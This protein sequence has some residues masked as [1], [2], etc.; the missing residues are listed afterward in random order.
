MTVMGQASREWWSIKEGKRLLIGVE[1][2]RSLEGVDFPP[3]L[4]NFLLLF[5]KA[6]VEISA[7]FVHND[8][9]F[10]LLDY[11]YHSLRVTYLKCPETSYSVHRNMGIVSPYYYSS[12]CFYRCLP[13]SKDMV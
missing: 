11:I 3:E 8:E 6:V 7:T 9:Q 12:V 4:K 13:S 1:L 5:G 2:L 10:D